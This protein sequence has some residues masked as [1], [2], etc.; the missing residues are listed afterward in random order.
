MGKHKQ[1]KQDFVDWENN[2]VCVWWD[3]RVVMKIGQGQK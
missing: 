3:G 2:E 1:S